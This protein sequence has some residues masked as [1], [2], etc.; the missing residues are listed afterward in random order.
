M[1][2]EVYWDKTNGY[3][4]QICTVGMYDAWYFQ[5]NSN[6]DHTLTPTVHTLS[7]IV[8]TLV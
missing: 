8:H 2:L 4:K 5:E 3:T 1:I 7:Q 6:T